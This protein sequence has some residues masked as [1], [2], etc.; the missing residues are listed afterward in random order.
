MLI[1]T[2]IFS[3]IFYIKGTF[4]VF[5]HWWRI[6]LGDALCT[7][8][9]TCHTLYT[10]LV[11]L[12]VPVPGLH[13]IPVAELT[14]HH[15]WRRLRTKSVGTETNLPIRQFW[16]RCRYRW[17]STGTDSLLRC[18]FGIWVAV[19][20]YTKRYFGCLFLGYRHEPL[21]VCSKLSMLLL[22]SLKCSKSTPLF[23]CFKSCF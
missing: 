3:S 17:E 10:F 20:Y 9:C 19:A 5:F 4:F 23:V 2:K 7:C 22:L 15:Y 11:P 21:G 8:T 13:L 1:F 18:R 16:C 14:W 12:R 6:F